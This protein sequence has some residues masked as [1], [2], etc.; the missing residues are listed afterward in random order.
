MEVKQLQIFIILDGSKHGD[1][2]SKLVILVLVDTINRHFEVWKLGCLFR[3]LSYG[4]EIRED[5]GFIII[6]YN[7]CIISRDLGLLIELI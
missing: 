5:C 7:E 2:S 1:D 4:V 3:G 6:I